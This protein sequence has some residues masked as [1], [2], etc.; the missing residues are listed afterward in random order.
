MFG[1][2][3]LA[4]QTELRPTIPMA[5]VIANDGKALVWRQSGEGIFERVIVTTGAQVGDRV[6][7]VSGLAPGD[8]VVV[9]GVMLLVAN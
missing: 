6:A 4:E 9:D 8:R 7:I 2:I 3:Q 1:N 5:A